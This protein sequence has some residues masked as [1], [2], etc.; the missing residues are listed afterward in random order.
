MKKQV[1]IIHGGN[2]YQSYKDYIS[3]LRKS[4]IDFENLSYQG[5]KDGLKEKLGRGF[6]VVIPRMPSANNA[7]YLEW[8]I[9]FEKIVPHLEKEVVL[10]GHSLGATFLAKFLSEEKF[11]KKVLA[12]ILVAAPFDDKDLGGSLADFKLKKD[13]SMLQKQSRELIFF[14]SIDDFVVPFGDFLK[15][16]KSLPDATFREFKK[17]GHFLQKTFPQIVGEIKRLFT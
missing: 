3:Y 14:H 5:W 6:S 17:R 7:K 15:F 8:K 13:L 1:V 12:T 10:V 2:T 9:W 16:K 11:S 4:E